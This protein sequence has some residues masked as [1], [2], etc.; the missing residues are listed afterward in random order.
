[1]KPLRSIRLRLLLFSLIG[2]LAAVAVATAG[3]VTLF[4][5]HVERRVEQELD[6][7]IATLAG[8]LRVASGGSLTLAR[9]PSDARFLKP[10]GGLYWQV[11]DEK[12]G[13]LL[14]SV[15]LWDSRLA[16]PDDVLPA[17]ATHTHRSIATDQREVIVHERRIIL[18]TPTGDRPARISVAV[19][20]AETNQLKAGFGRDLVPGLALLG[21]VLL[22][23][24]W[25]QVGAGLK[26]LASIRSAI[27]AVREG[28]SR[29]LTLAAP[30]EIAPLVA[31]VNELLEAQEAAL[32]Q[33]RHRAADIAHGLKTPLTALAGDIARL[34]A[35]N[36]HEFADDIEA[37]AH[38]MRRIVEREL[39][40]SRR[41]HGPQALRTP[42]RAAVEAI[43]R[44][45]A[46]T[47]AGEAVAWDMMIENGV[48]VA[49]DGDDFNDILGN[50]MENAARVAQGRV[51]VRAVQDGARV[52]FA[53]AD[54]GPQVN[55][56]AIAGLIE[57]GKRMDE[58]GGS[59]GLGLA[60]VAEILEA[61]ESAPRFAVSD[62][63]GLEVSFALPAAQ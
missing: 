55:T 29:C 63:G 24:G 39:A 23:A 47:P 61:H 5:R 3:L 21:A 20:E 59:A 25:M 43:A 52:D 56:M 18:D 10:F 51:R 35:S 8:N 1:V 4:G 7:H 44:T 32:S 11:L 62:L 6:A 16:L 9:E 17:G 12:T 41:R 27:A 19:N 28:R 26:P 58:S 36:Q 30:T 45:L 37:V 53:V 57:R 40:R 42:V 14:R 48:A 22:V 34:R 38:Q 31:E 60:I 50:L 33:A 13:N 15:S 49:V 54:D 2:T 46:R